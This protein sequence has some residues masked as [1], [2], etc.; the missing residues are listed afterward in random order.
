MKQP[1]QRRAQAT[2]DRILDAAETL[3]DQHGYDKTS[4]NSLAEHAQVSIGGLYE[5]FKN[6]EAVL[7]AVA[8]RHVEVA[9]TRI[10]TRLTQ[11]P[12]LD[13]NA[14]IRIVL[15]EGLEL[16]QSKPKLHQF[17]YAEAPRPKALRDM[18]KRFDEALEKM[19]SEHLIEQGV[20]PADATLR[21]ALVTRAGQALLH[22]FVLDDQLPRSDKKRLQLLTAPLLRLLSD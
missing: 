17:L 18:L 22:D 15:E 21:S 19:V 1:Q 9:S 4:M 7:T 12:T 2:R 3:F 14:R 10:L 20:S 6:K 13:I 8:Q 11:H 16:H 5:W